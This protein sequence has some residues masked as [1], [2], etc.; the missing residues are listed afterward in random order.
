ME[1]KL[2]KIE[3]QLTDLEELESEAGLY[4]NNVIKEIK[5]R[6]LELEHQRLELILKEKNIESI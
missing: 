3:R 6:R 4:K 5:S 1:T 2:Q